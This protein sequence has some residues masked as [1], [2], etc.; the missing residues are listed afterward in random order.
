MAEYNPW[1]PMSCPK[2]IKTIGKCQEEC[3]ELQAALSRCLIQGIDEV[4]PVTGKINR[5]WLEDELADV[6]ATTQLVIKRFKLD[7]DKM[8][9]RVTIKLPKLRKWQDDEIVLDT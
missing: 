1:K 6:M 2:E 4:E 5:D 7:E 9:D 8:I 3:G